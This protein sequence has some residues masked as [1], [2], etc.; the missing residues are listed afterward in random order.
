MFSARFFLIEHHEGQQWTAA[1][2]LKPQQA[3]SR[4]P[5]NPAVGYINP[6]HHPGGQGSNQHANMNVKSCNFGRN[7][8]P[9]KKSGI[10]G[11]ESD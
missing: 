5:A 4:P 6:E 9:R 7:A 2:T 1:N 11:I 8:V 3:S 10:R